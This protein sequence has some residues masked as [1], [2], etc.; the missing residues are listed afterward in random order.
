MPGYAH[1]IVFMRN[2][3]V[4]INLAMGLGIQNSSYDYAKLDN[5]E[6]FSDTRLNFAFNSRFATGYNSPTF[7]GGL[8]FFWNQY[9]ENY[10]D[11][12]LNTNSIMI[13]LFFGYR[14][15]EWGVLKKSIFD[16]FPFLQSKYGAGYGARIDR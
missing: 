4:S 6:H 1:T 5:Y 16:V 7:F 11:V 2:L 13:K 14:I 12:K 3:Y 15:R 9:Q 8:T 10:Q